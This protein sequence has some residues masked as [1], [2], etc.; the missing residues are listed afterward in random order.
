MSYRTPQTSFRGVASSPLS[1][2]VWMRFAQPRRHMNHFQF[3]SRAMALG[4]EERVGEVV[5]R[6]DIWVGERLVPKAK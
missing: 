4:V 5:Q 3:G 1:A 6:M 2:G